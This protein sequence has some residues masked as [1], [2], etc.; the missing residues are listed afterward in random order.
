MTLDN[1]CMLISGS[2]GK[3]MSRHICE[4][5]LLELA[6]VLVTGT[7]EIDSLKSK[8]SVGHLQANL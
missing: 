4:F 5:E 1:P 6:K 8:L 3:P 2:V 7:C